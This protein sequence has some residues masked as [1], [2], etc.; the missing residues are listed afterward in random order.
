M[1]L[2]PSRFARG[3]LILGS[4]SAIHGGVLLLQ[5][6]WITAPLALAQDAQGTQVSPASLRDQYV[7]CTITL[8]SSD[9]REEIKRRYSQGRSA[10]RFYFVELTDV[11][12]GEGD[13]WFDHA[14]Q[15]VKAHQIECDQLVISGHFSDG[16]TGDQTNKTLSLSA[17]ERH[18]CDQDCGGIL[19]Q[20]DEVYLLGCNT[21]AGKEADSRTPQRYIEV[22]M[23]HG[24]SRIDA[25]MIADGRYG[26]GNLSNRER[27]SSVFSNAQQ[28]YGFD[29]V[30]PLGA[31]IRGSLRS[32][33]Q[34]IDPV[35]QLES[36]KAQRLDRELDYLNRGLDR[37]LS[38]NYAF[39][40]LS[41]NPLEAEDPRKLSCPLVSAQSSLLQRLQAVEGILGSS[42]PERFLSL[43][44]LEFENRLPSQIGN[45]KL[46]EDEIASL[47]RIAEGPTRV[48]FVEAI[49]LAIEMGIS[50]R[51]IEL[52]DLAL[53]LGWLSAKEYLAQVK[54]PMLEL[55]RASASEEDESPNEF[56]CDPK[57]M[58]NRPRLTLSSAEAASLP[59]TSGQ[60]LSA[61]SCVALG[62]AGASS[63][64][65]GQGLAAFV[66]ARLGSEMGL[67]TSAS[68]GSGSGS[69]SGGGGVRAGASSLSPL[70]RA[71]AIDALGRWFPD[72]VRDEASGRVLASAMK[73][74]THETWVKGAQLLRSPPLG[75]GESVEVI[76]EG[77]RKRAAVTMVAACEA[78]G[79]IPPSAESRVFLAETL[80]DR[81]L[82]YSKC[83]ADQAGHVLSAGLS[84]TERQEW[85]ERLKQ[86]ALAQ[87]DRETRDRWMRAHE[88]VKQGLP[89]R[90]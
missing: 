52:A 53:N 39:C 71:S 78:L 87:E 65:A 29:S 23:E 63:S 44:Q 76:R 84:E 16:F 74:S 83:L 9:E 8:G 30:A 24:E 72:G 85:A 15:F 90:E 20:P 40:Q 81:A 3:S 89:A 49:D 64:D 47:V 33:L 7:V 50:S 18:H 26:T 75:A 62:G 10:G 58:R 17:L 28:L 86:N 31:H 70:V 13:D 80:G 41:S 22:L 11:S 54:K 32:Y 27:M 25:E 82:D 34:S 37:A 61:L 5:A 1:S 14:C 43:L 6:G 68:P 55:V 42:H 38:P 69:G 12:P 67:S 46:S 77:Y 56:L 51:A 4:L 45:F 88:R 59:L 73:G 19:S 66:V 2:G 36:L 21:L 35:T 57:R 60:T 48:R 79:R